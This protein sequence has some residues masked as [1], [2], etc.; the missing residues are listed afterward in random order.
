MFYRA[1]PATRPARFE[2]SGDW[3]LAFPA[4]E[5]LKFV[6]V[7]RGAGWLLLPDTAPQ[8][9]ETGDCC[10]IGRTAYVIASDPGLV[11]IDG[12][13]LY[14]DGNDLVRLRG[15]DT[16]MLGGGISFTPGTAAFLLDMLPAFMHVSGR[17]PAA[18]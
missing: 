3:A 1:M 7:L 4:L 16:V 6:A 2:G 9:I 14:A 8:R 5:R 13:S 10:L 17:S 15:D 11:P 18:A 12:M